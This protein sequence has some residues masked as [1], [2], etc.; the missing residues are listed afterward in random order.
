MTYV[1]KSIERQLVRISF[2]IDEVFSSI[3]GQSQI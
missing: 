1:F 3:S 2:L